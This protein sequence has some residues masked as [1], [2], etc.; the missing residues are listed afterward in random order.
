MYYFQIRLLGIWVWLLGLYQM[1]FPLFSFGHIG[2]MSISNSLSE[3]KLPF[4]WAY[5]SVF[6]TRHDRYYSLSFVTIFRL[7]V[8][9]DGKS[10][11]YHHKQPILFRNNSMTIVQVALLMRSRN[12]YYCLSDHKTCIESFL[13][14]C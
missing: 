1:Q 13:N 4:I 9:A 10:V 6:I 11:G 7:V 2:Q 3:S 5:H 14:F 12:D 8:E